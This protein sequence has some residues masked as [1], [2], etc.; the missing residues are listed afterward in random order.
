MRTSQALEYTKFKVTYRFLHRTKFLEFLS[1]SSVL[2]VPSK[3]SAVT[4]MISL[5]KLNKGQNIDKPNE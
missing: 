1:Q 5:M 3:A 4:E 2:S